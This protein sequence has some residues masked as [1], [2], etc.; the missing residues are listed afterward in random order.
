RCTIS[1]GPAGRRGKLRKVWMFPLRLKS[2]ARKPVLTV[3]QARLV[4]EAQAKTAKKL[5]LDEL[6]R[7]AAK[8]KGEPTRRTAQATTYVRDAAVAELVRRLANGV[9]DL[10]EK[11][12]PFEDKHGE[13]Y[14]ESHHVEWLAKGGADTVE[15]AVALCPNCHRKMHVRDLPAGR[16]KL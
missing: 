2:R 8:A 7:R 13:P 12:A 9:C 15:N 10:C 3:E 14:L 16:R 5:A 11:P 6:R 4:E 1:R